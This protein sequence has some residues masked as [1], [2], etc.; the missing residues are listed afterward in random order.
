MYGLEKCNRCHVETKSKKNLSKNFIKYIILYVHLKEGS[1]CY[2]SSVENLS[3]FLLFVKYQGKK[4]SRGCR[5]VMS[6][7]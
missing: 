2:T 7:K 5:I 6:S 3:I 1:I 4:N